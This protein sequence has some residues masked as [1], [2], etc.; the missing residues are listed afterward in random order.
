MSL[1]A[2]AV[3]GAKW[4]TASSIIS[5]LVQ[6]AQIAVLARL[7]EPE[8]FGLMAMIMIVIG[9]A[10]IYA[11]AG[12]SSALIYRQEATRETLSSLY[13]LNLFAGIAIFLIALLTMP[14]ISIAFSEPRL[15]SLVP[16]AAIVF[17]IIPF[18]QQF[19]VLLQRDLSFKILGTIE[20]GAAIAGAAA[21]IG[22]A[23]LDFGV[24]SLIIGQIVSML[25]AT[26]ALV[27]VGWHRWKPSWH[28][29]ILD[30]EGYFSF[31]LYQMGEKSVN[32]FNSRTDQLLLGV[33]LGPHSLGLYNLAWSLVIQPI[34]R[35]NPILVRVA[36]PLFAKVQDDRNRLKRGYFFLVWILTAINGPLLIGFS[37][38][39][40]LFIPIFL[41][42][43]WTET[44][45]IVQILAFVS[46]FRSISNPIGSLFLATGR[47]DLGFKWNLLLL[48]LQ[49]IAVFAGAHFGGLMGVAISVLVMQIVY[50]PLLYL[51]LIRT[52]LGACLKEY[53]ASFLPIFVI[54]MV[55]GLVVLAISETAP[56]TPIFMLA[57]QITLGAIFYVVLCFLLQRKRIEE[58]R[59]L[60]LS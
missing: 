54:S 60:L 57:A 40:T 36:F 10:Q 25:V 22:T 18:G 24:L 8:D 13:F 16:I 15:K 45:S 19:R 55:M 44:I 14:L 5:I 30:L 1:K 52:L 32:F 3:S 17:L 51:L 21:A 11:D 34:T 56:A 2:A 33:L 6:F 9:F 49:P 12:I 41:G 42:D 47:A 59:Q 7:L 29:R 4:T 38:V 28:F 37:A 53:I 58:V 31:G 23:I 20:A 43:R 48:C 50:I 39:A 26:L 35:I 27:I 46:F